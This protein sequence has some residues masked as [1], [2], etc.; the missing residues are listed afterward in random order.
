ML[1]REMFLKIKPEHINEV[2]ELYRKEIIP[3][4]KNVKGCIDARLLAPTANTEE[5]IAYSEWKTKGEVE[6]YENG[7]V[8]KELRNKVVKFTTIEPVLRT[9]TFEKAQGLV[10]EMH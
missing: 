7:P 10:P 9:Y 8:Y 2:K 5:F 3:A 6:L 4:L 1:V